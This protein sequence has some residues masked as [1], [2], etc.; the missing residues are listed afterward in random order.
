MDGNDVGMLEG[1]RSHS[2]GAKPLDRLSRRPW[3]KQEQLEGNGSVQTLLAGP[4]DYSH[5][6]LS[7]L[8]EQFV[9]AELM[10]DLRLPRVAT[11]AWIF[12]DL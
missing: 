7:N 4:I 6:A 9:V 8:L 2:F 11:V 12:S 1:S 3:S 5:P 10:T